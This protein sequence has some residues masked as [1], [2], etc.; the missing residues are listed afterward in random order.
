M[1]L[2]DLF[3]K[4]IDMPVSNKK[5]SGILKHN[6]LP[7]LGTGVQAIAYYHK[8]FPGK[9]V[10]MITIE[11]PNDPSYQ[12]LRLCV[13]HPENPYFPKIY[14]F[15]QYNTAGED[16]EATAVDRDEKYEEIDPT[17]SPPMWAKH[18]VLVV[19][20]KL[21][22]LSSSQKM[23]IK[24]L[25]MIGI[26]PTNLDD[27]M[28]YNNSIARSPLDYT[29]IP[30]EGKSGRVEL[31]NRTKDVNLKKA[32]RLLEPLFNKFYPDMRKTNIMLRKGQGGTHIV[33]TDPVC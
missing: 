15:K 12:Y 6:N 27:L 7:H 33:I 32:L 19:M 17:D 10:K 14:A 23:S 25:Q 18:Q 9:V 30:F 2:Q 21:H 8:K 28:K 5:T 13:N 16:T 24:M 4:K 3:E 26:L 22:D 20:E 31:Y 11:G 1:K 29:K